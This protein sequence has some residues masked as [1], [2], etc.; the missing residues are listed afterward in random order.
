MAAAVAALPCP[1]FWDSIAY[2]GLIT[3]STGLR[4]KC[5][6]SGDGNPAW[7]FCLVPGMGLN[8]K[9]EANIFSC[10]DSPCADLPAHINSPFYLLW[11]YF[12]LIGYHTAKK[13]QQKKQ[14]NMKYNK[15]VGLLWY[16]AILLPIRRQLCNKMGPVSQSSSIMW[17]GR[18][19]PSVCAP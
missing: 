15:T 9:H 18:L 16:A 17:L 8:I 7:H 2:Y 12:N 4:L 11:T 10:E 14:N 3:P 6:V 5:S 13:R 19:W 1:F